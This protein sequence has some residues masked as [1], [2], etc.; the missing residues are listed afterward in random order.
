MLHTH[1][2]ETVPLMCWHHA[3]TLGWVKMLG[4]EMMLVP[5]VQEW[6]GVE[7]KT[8]PYKDSGTCIVGGTD[9]VQTI[10]DDQIVKIQAISASPFVAPFR[11]RAS[12]HEATLQTLQV[13]LQ[14]VLRR[15][16]C[17]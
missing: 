4:G 10:L 5:V 2:L 1:Y 12:G 13:P 9:D 14:S 8:T 6:E 16:P 17:T 7:L 11:E 15:S 3:V